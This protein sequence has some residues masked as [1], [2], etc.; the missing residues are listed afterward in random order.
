M[1]IQF[2][3]AFALLCMA[4]GSPAAGQSCDEKLP[5]MIQVDAS[6]AKCFRQIDRRFG[7]R[8]LKDFSTQC[9]VSI[10]ATKHTGMCKK[11]D[12][13]DGATFDIANGSVTISK[14]T[15][16]ITIKDLTPGPNGQW[17]KAH[18]AMFDIDYY[19]FMLDIF[20]TL[21]EIP[22]IYRVEAFDN[23][24]KSKDCLD[25]RPESQVTQVTGPEDPACPHY[26][27]RRSKMTIGD[28]LKI[29]ILE[30]DVGTGIEP[31]R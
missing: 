25:E 3:A 6:E 2:V 13:I 11:V 17:L 5:Q 28:L 22:K 19:F 12:L 4:M 30:A 26:S 27:D 16:A 29:V 14:G 23:K 8:Q 7:I 10:A 20:P 15:S 9:A 31:R 1:R 24:D 21:N 18:D